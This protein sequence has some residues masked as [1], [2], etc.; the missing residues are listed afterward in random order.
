[1]LADLTALGRLD[2]AW[3]RGQK[4]REEFRER[5]LA[6]EADAG[7][8][9]LV[10]H[11]KRE[12]ARHATHIGLLQR[13]DRKQRARQRLGR[14]CV[15][16]VALILASVDAAEQPRLRA[17]VLDASVVAG[18]NPL[19]AEPPRIVEAH[20]K[21]DLAI[22]QHVGVRRAARAV[23][24]EK[25]R[26]HALAVLAREAHLVQ[27]NAQL[28]AHAARI[29]EIL[30]SGAVTV[31]VFVPVAHEEPLYVVALLQ[32]ERGSDGRVDAAGHADDYGRGGHGKRMVSA[33]ARARGSGPGDRLSASAD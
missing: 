3:L 29:L 32:Q 5:S 13:A 33:K 7:A 6:D 18:G 11:R 1:M 24:L 20:A 4:L 25:V 17:T 9:L 30:G 15:Q 28:L 10:E 21:L 31:L 8:V 19:G 16:E 27:R 14:H 23:L 12:L 22:A 2:V 26:E